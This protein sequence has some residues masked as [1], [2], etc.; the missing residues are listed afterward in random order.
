MF[1]R[2]FRQKLRPALEW[3]L[4]VSMC[5]SGVY[6]ILLFLGWLMLPLFAA[7]L[8]PILFAIGVSSVGGLLETLRIWFGCLFSLLWQARWT[9]VPFLVWL[10]VN[11][12]GFRER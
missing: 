2:T 1:D 7:I 10:I 5:A 8:F 3:L 6:L 11:W 4:M 12:K 9:V